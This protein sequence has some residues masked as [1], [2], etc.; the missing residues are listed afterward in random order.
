MLFFLDTE[1][2]DFIDIELISLAL[3]AEDGSRELYLEVADFDRAKCNA[4]V[5]AAVLG[6][7][8]RYPAALTRQADVGQRLRDWFATLPRRVTIA[9]DSQHDR[10]L[11]VDAFDGDLPPN[12]AGWFDLRPCIDTGVFNRAVE[13]F[14][15]K[16]RPWHHALY[17]AQAH[18]AGYNRLASTRAMLRHKAAQREQQ[19][20]VPQF[21]RDEL[22][23]E[24]AD[25]D[26]ARRGEKSD[27]WGRVAKQQ[28]QIRDVVGEE[29]YMKKR[30]EKR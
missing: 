9:C 25:P 29:N 21:L 24:L 1:F 3:V 22:A 4:F 17:D 26:P 8:G 19:M 14:H 2:T 5:Q 13:E 27:P 15:T 28:Q 23:E 7:L 30:R 10:D 16:E 12:F 18:R 6:Y 20:E 11:L